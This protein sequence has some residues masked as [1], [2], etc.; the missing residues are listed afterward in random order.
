M[1]YGAALAW[2]IFIIVGIL[3]AVLFGTARFWVHYG[4][5]RS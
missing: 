1:G 3:T 2:F 4:T 5:E